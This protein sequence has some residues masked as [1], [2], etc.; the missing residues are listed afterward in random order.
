MVTRI[1]RF[2]QRRHHRLIARQHI[3][4]LKP[5]LV[6]FL[7][8]ESLLFHPQRRIPVILVGVKLPFLQCVIAVIN[9]G[10]VIKV[11]L[12]NVFIMFKLRLGKFKIALVIFLLLSK[13]C[14]SQT[15][16]LTTGHCL[17]NSAESGK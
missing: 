1:N 13:L 10:S 5:S 7:Q 17:V 11:P 16:L 4:I 3:V 6:V 2:S 15:K 8:L 9:F 12:I 14:F